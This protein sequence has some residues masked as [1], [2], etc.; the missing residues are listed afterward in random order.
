M[1]GIVLLGDIDVGYHTCKITLPVIPLPVP[2]TLPILVMSDAH[3]GIVRPF[4]LRPFQLMLYPMYLF[5]ACLSSHITPN[6]TCWY[7]YSQKTMD[8]NNYPPVPLLPPFVSDPSH[9]GNP[10]AILPHNGNPG[11]V[12]ATFDVSTGMVIHK[13]TV[14][15]LSLQCKTSF[16]VW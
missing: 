4:I 3:T 9:N 1:M 15:I 12:I 16:L 14:L 8:G 5:R 7:Q 13:I 6:A 10:G 11:T 2:V